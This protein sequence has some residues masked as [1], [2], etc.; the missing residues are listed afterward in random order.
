MKKIELLAPAKDLL[1]GITAIQCGAD[2]VYIGAGKFG[3]RASAANSLEDIQKLINF[4]HK[5]WAKVYI[6]INTVLTDKEI[7][8]AQK[9]IQRL[10]EIGADAIIVQDM[11][12]LELDLP[13]VPLFASTQAHNNTWQ[14]VDFL[15]KVGFQRVILPRELN[16]TQIKEI[17]SKTNIDLEFF[18]HG[19]LCVSYSGQCYMSY[20]NGGRSGN[21]GECAQP[22]RKAYT[23]T[24]SKGKIIAK[25]KYLLSL[26][27]M[28]LSDY[29]DDLIEAG[30]TSLK[31]EGRLKDVNYIKNIVSYYRQK[32]DKK[33]AEFPF[34]PQKTF[35]RGFTS[36][37]LTGR[38]KNIVSSD[39][40]KHIGEPMGNIENAKLNNGDGITYFDKDNTLLGT[41]DFKA[42]TA[43]TKI[44]RNYDHEYMKALKSLKIARKIGV[45]IA[46][47][48]DCL[49][50]TD[51]DGNTIEYK[52]NFDFEPAQNTE[53][54]LQNIQ[55]Q[56][57][58]LGETDF[59][60][61]EVLLDFDVVPFIPVNTLNEIRRQA[62]KMLEDERL[63][64]FPRSFH[65]IIQNDFPYPEKELDY[66]ANVLNSY[67]RKFYDRHGVT[68]I[69]PA[70]ESGIDMIDNKLMTCKHCL[71]FQFNMCKKS[72]EPLFLADEHNKY[73][74]EF[75][76]KKCEMS[77]YFAN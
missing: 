6:T 56:L 64:N 19:S 17:K 48:A 32:L 21:R 8:E 59:C 28:N 13:P 7:S 60:A 3:A 77:V 44:Y 45:K 66:S 24:N 53:M 52:I 22:C 40:P 47:N 37:F 69:D 15:E 26:N 36:Y 65:K 33:T 25:D 74:L 46:F 38:N 29:L 14:K 62:V 70:A 54:A 16:L 12:F 10:Y 75:D 42:I 49:K 4:A 73:R 50:F 39:S 43:G 76:C 11:G 71:K 41:N 34:S 9:L 30:I 5:Y 18:V 58:K 63:H 27:D 57:S 51:E 20:A 23:L 67:A 2:A 35:N 55:K 72:S 31:I 1:T 68:S 61:E